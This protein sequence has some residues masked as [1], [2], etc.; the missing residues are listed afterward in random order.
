[1][2]LTVKF[3]HPGLAPDFLPSVTTVAEAH[4]DRT[5]QLFREVVSEFVLDLPE[6]KVVAALRLTELLLLLRGSQRNGRIRE[7]PLVAALKPFMAAHLAEVVSLDDMAKVV[8]VSREHLCRVFKRET[9]ETP[10]GHLRSL[11]VERAKQLLAG[12]HEPISA[13][14]ERTGFTDVRD[15]HRV[16]KRL[17]GTGPRE[18]R[19]QTRL[20]YENI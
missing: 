2:N 10:V 13:V 18:Y 11:R 17:T 5:V 1:V 19:R 12:G 20:A 7:H 3:L 8:D 16:F 9:G 14:A 6:R 4:V 15:F